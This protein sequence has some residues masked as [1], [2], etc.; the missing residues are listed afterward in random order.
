M[1]RCSST[2][3]SRRPISVVFETTL[4]FQN[5]G[6]LLSFG[7]DGITIF[8]SRLICRSELA[9]LFDSSASVSY[10]GHPLNFCVA[11]IEVIQKLS[12]IF[13]LIQNFN[14]WFAFDEF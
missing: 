10:A 5:N 7:N 11:V 3:T 13:D 9:S 14:R 8:V 6:H 12:A 4:Y 1:L 2:A